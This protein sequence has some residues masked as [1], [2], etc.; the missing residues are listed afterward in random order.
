MLM[1]N[2]IEMLTY[3]RP[4]GSDTQKDFCIKYLHPTLGK[5]D[6]DGNYVKIVGKNP[7]VA[8]AAHHDTVHMREGIQKLKISG[9]IISLPEGSTSSCLGADCTTGVWLILE[10]VK[11]NIPGVYLVHAAEESGCIGS[12]ALVARNHK[13]MRQLDAVI[14]FDRKGQESIITHQ[15]SFRTCS[16]DFAVSLENILDLGL[17][18]DDTGSYTDSNEYAHH[19]SECTN[20]SVGYLNQHTNRETQDMSFAEI[21]R[22]SLVSADWSKLKFSRDKNIAEYLSPLEWDKGYKSY[23][24]NSKYDYARPRS[25]E[26]LDSLDDIPKEPLND[27]DD[28]LALVQQ[29][30]YE[31]AMILESFGFLAEDFREEI[32]PSFYSKAKQYGGK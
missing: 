21:L 25:W 12:K 18:A 22:D 30:P 3:C 14:S 16:N 26:E 11:A 9:N 32:D 24:Y 27:F 5:P 23:Q 17:K 7:N 20:L 2:L 4:Q 28:L 6:K 8:F 29:Y 31:A 13:W 1:E 19:V 15:M 10:M